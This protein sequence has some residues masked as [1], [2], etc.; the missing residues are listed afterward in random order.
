MVETGSLFEGVKQDLLKL[1]IW[2][3]RESKSTLILE[4]IKYQK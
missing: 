3:D 4:M 1:G 2:H